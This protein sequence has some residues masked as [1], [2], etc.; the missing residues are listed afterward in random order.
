[1]LDVHPPH[2][3]VHGVRDF[4]LHLL[5]ITC[6]LLIAL[7]LEASVE[8]I[9]HR[10]QREHAEAV[11]RQELTANRDLL[12]HLQQENR[13]ELAT[14]EKL[15][16]FLEGLRAGRVNDP[17]PLNLDYNT[18]PLQSAGWRTAS[19]TGALT[20]MSYEEE[21]RF[22]TAYQF[23]QR[24]EDHSTAAFHPFELLYT[25]EREHTDP[26]TWKPEEIDARI[27]VVRE[28]IADLSTTWDDGRGLEEF[29]NDAL[30][31]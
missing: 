21:Q 26:R 23:Q 16:A 19:A 6:G 1:M 13:K 2:A 10:H 9:H 11:L 25:F 17:G 30:K 7:G 3:P 24:H 8:A 12:A 5:T 27:A 14:L 18:E 4:F 20:Y 31:Q 15:L 22:E 28:C 29:Y